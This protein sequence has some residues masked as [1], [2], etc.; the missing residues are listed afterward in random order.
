MGSVVALSLV[1][2]SHAQKSGD[3][4][5]QK[6]ADKPAP[7]L[8]KQ[9]SADMSQESMITSMNGEFDIPNSDCK[10]GKFS[11]SGLS[12]TSDSYYYCDELGLRYTLKCQPGSKCVKYG[13]SI[14]CDM[15]DDITDLTGATRSA[16]S[17]VTP[18]DNSDYGISSYCKG[19][20]SKNGSF[21]TV[22]RED[23]EYYYTCYNKK[24]K[25]IHCPN[26]S[27]CITGIN[28]AYCAYKISD[29]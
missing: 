3:K 24:A 21:C 6:G 14:S 18:V 2:F 1:T 12:G 8:G 16:R 9:V 13:D 26:G 23:N 5:Q 4:Q 25:K 10:I 27:Q 19:K 22:G 11:C 17:R 7:Q 20:N 29:E 15:V 28:G